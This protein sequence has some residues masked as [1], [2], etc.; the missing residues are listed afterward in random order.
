MISKA[1]EEFGNRGEQS[2]DLQGL[3]RPTS[4]GVLA[5]STLQVGNN[6]YSDGEMTTALSWIPIYVPIKKKIIA[7]RY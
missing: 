4:A 3:R 6:G 7:H 5:A 1:D 2:R